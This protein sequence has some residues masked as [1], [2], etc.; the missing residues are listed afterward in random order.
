MVEY[1]SLIS[2]T[3]GVKESLGNG[4]GCGTIEEE[5]VPWEELEGLLQPFYGKQDGTVGRRPYPLGMLL[6]IHFLQQWYL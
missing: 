1:A 4:E 6:P 2:G 3:N 5:V